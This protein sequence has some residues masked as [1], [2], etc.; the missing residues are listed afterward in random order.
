MATAM[1]VTV[2]M[3]VGFMMLT[4]IDCNEA[5]TTTTTR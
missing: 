3:T 4:R 2:P 5:T 1:A